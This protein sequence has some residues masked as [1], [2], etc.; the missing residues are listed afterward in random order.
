MWFA[1][2]T[3]ILTYPA[4][5]LQSG[6]NAEAVTHDVPKSGKKKEARSDKQKKEAPS[7]KQK[8]ASSK[9]TRLVDD[10]DYSEDDDSSSPVEL[11]AE[12]VDET[13]TGGHAQ[14]DSP[15]ATVQR[16][17]VLKLNERDLLA[18][19]HDVRKVC[20]PHDFPYLPHPS[21][22]L[23]SP[24]VRA[25]KKGCAQC[26]GDDDYGAAFNG[27]APWPPPSRRQQGPQDVELFYQRLGVDWQDLC[28]CV[29]KTPGPSA[30]VSCREGVRRRDIWSLP[31]SRPLV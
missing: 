13:S 18:L 1:Q 10:N 9:G 29:M 3:Q 15:V 7:D 23:S 31:A 24:L 2:A 21:A 11:G 19:L 30:C 17:D 20:T 14:V 5:R 6:A 27:E 28:Q 22:H 25:E 16:A 12:V 8:K 26:D 4:Q